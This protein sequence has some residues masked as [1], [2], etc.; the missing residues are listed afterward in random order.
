MSRAHARSANYYHVCNRKRVNRN[1]RQ[2]KTA[3]SGLTGCNQNGKTTQD[4]FWSCRPRDTTLIVVGGK[5]HSKRFK[6][7]DYLERGNPL[8]TLTQLVESE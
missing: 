4:C 7:T 8:V 6:I 2:H 5:T 1:H 3:K